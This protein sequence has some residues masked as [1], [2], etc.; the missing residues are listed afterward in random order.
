MKRDPETY[1][2]I[3]RLYDQWV[4]IQREKPAPPRRV[5][6]AHPSYPSTPG[7]S[8]MG[9]YAFAAAGVVIGVI[10]LALAAL[11]FYVSAGWA[12]LGRYGAATGYFVV[13]FFL[14]ISGAGGIAA[15]LNHNFRVLAQPDGHH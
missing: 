12:D 11:S 15:T 2:G 3:R 1:G 8:D 13:G 5:L 4:E 9:K 7:G 6:P 10:I 14:V